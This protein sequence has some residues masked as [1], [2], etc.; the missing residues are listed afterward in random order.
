MCSPTDHS[1][2][3]ARDLVRLTAIEWVALICAAVVWVLALA[4]GRRFDLLVTEVLQMILVQLTWLA[5]CFVIRCWAALVRLSPRRE[6]VIH[7]IYFALLAA[8]LFG[9]RLGVSLTELYVAEGLGRIA[10][11]AGLID[12][13]LLAVL[14]LVILTTSRRDPEHRRRV[15]IRQGREALFIGRLLLFYIPVVA[16]YSNLSVMIPQLNPLDMSGGFHAI[17][18]A[19]L[20]GHD[21]FALLAGLQSPWLTELMKESYCFFF[22]FIIFGLSAAILFGR[23]R[24]FQLIFTAFCLV[25][26]IGA[27]LYVLLPSVGP[28]FHEGTRHLLPEMAKGT[29]RHR[30]WAAHLAA[31]ANPDS[32]PV[33]P[34]NGLAAFPSLHI[35]HSTLFLI[36]L[37]RVQRVLVFLLLIPFLLLTLSTVYLGWHWVCDIPG[38]VGLAVVSL[39]L[40]RRLCSSGSVE[41]GPAPEK[42]LL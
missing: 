7:L 3:G 4:V 17:D 33:F 40:A 37:W 32:A 18:R 21:P 6:R 15:L 38:G 14:L 31:L 26:L 27:A 24:S 9:W 28:A 10:Q 29:M 11:M 1:E 8:L 20:L 41:S 39:L 2:I 22:F 30:H 12:A 16:V 36:Y 13:G 35:A 19:L 34:F 42:D 23:V 5:P 25:Y